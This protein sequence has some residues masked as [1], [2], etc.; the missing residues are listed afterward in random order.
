MM[1]MFIMFITVAFMML[2][3]AVPIFV[4]IFAKQN[5]IDTDMRPLLGKNKSMRI[6]PFN[7]FTGIRCLIW[8]YLSITKQNY[9]SIF[10]LIFKKFTKIF[11]ISFEILCIN[12][13]NFFLYLD[14]LINR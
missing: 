2:D 11:Q 5:F 8:K 13:C 7:Q 4:I 10:Y 1:M 12:S 6:Y 9:I 14:I 3:T